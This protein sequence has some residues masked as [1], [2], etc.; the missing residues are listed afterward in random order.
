MKRF[1]VLL[2]SMIA[3]CTV[4]A[5]VSTQNYI[6]SR[7]M[8]NNT[9]SSHVDDISYFDGL[10]RPFQSVNKTVQNNVTKQRLATLLEYDYY[11]RET[12]MW[13]PTSVMADYVEVSTFRNTAVGSSGYNDSYPYSQFI[14][15]ASP[16]NR[17]LQQYG[18]GKLWHSNNRAV[19][20]EYLVNASDSDRACKFYTVNGTSLSGGTEF[21]AANLLNVIK[22]TDEG[23]NVSY[24]FTDK[25]GRIVL[26]RQMNG[27]EA[28]D[29]YY[30]YNDKG[31]LCFVLQPMYQTTADIELYAFEYKYDGHGNCIWKKLPGAEYIEYVYD[32]YDRMT[33]SQDGNQRKNNRWMYYQYDAMGRPSGQGECTEKNRDSNPVQHIRSYYDGYYI[34][35]QS[36]FNNP[37]FPK[38]NTSYIKGRLAGSIISVPGSGS[39]IYIAYFYDIKG[40]VM[41]ETR[42]NLLGGHD[43]TITTYTFTDKPATVTHIHTASGKNTWIEVYTYSYDHADRISKVQHTLGG[44]TITLYDATYDDLGRLKTKSLHGSTTNKLTYTYNLRGW[45]TGITGTRLTQNLYYNT[46]VGTAK[47]NGSISSMTWK[48]GNESTVRGYKFTYDGLDRL[49]NGTYGEGEQLNSNSGRY[50]ENVTGYDK[51]G[52]IT[53]LERYGRSGSSSYGMCD[54]LTYTLN[55]N[56]MIRVDDQ[57]SIGAGNDETDFKDA[58]KQA[59]EYTYDANGNLTKDLNKGI[60]GITYNCLNLPNAV[61]FSDGSTVT[62]IYSADGT[63]LRAV[64]KIGSVTTTTDYCDNVIYENNTAKLLL[65]GEGYIS[66]SDKKYHYYL[67]DHQGNNRVV[68]DKDGNVE[69]TNHYYPFGGVFASSQNVQPYKYNG[70]ELDTKKGLNWY[71]YGAREYDAVLGRFTTMD[72]M[73]EKYYAVSPYT[74]CVNN[75]IKFVDPTGMLTESPQTGSIRLSF[76]DKIKN[77][78][79]DLFSFTVDIS[80]EE[81]KQKTAQKYN[82]QMSTLQSLNDGVEAVNTVMSIVN[83]VASVAEL[84]ANIQGENT[85]GIVLAGAM[86]ALDVATGGKGK[87]AKE[88]FKTLS[89]LGLR[90]GARV[91]SNKALE[92]GEQFLGKGYKEVVS[93]SGRYVSA[94]GTRVFRMGTSD[95]TGAHAGGSHVNFETLIPNPNKPGKMMVDKDLHIYLIE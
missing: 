48:A 3:A 2:I 79:N 12:N 93:G 43:V 24:T 86:V 95:I 29:T 25:L 44:T 58:V 13:L 8:L 11:G 21:Y 38:G 72:P 4:S 56:Q 31:N 32:N 67:Q 49:L 57:V 27:T 37:D 84:A 14:Y 28:H 59:N 68:A 73:A 35:S 80:S 61:T 16:L 10:G 66:L 85:K 39:K 1:I 71:D 46:G 62:Y 76:W 23:N 41:Q 40:R 5:Q 45:L 88:T 15:E 51:N 20:T 74:Y 92:L 54:A 90:N 7:K 53:G 18:A 9:G 75:P 65:T 6:C 55:G 50:S 78:F 30:V 63:K 83:P 17:P 77:A 26:T 33:Y 70:K 89:E 69:E 94:D 64:H 91:T 19:R 87:G 22:T 52:N 81:A 34:L 42:S 36:G 60:T 82:R 47:Y